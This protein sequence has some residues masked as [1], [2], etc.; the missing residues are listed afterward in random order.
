MKNTR[1]RVLFAGII[2]LGFTHTATAQ[3]GFKIYISA[4]M[5]G[6][7]GVVTGDQLGP[8]GFEYQRFRG[9]MTQEVNTAI[10][11]AFEGG[12]T[13]VV[14]S[15]S[16][17]NGENLLLEQ[18]PDNVVVIRSWPRPLSM[19]EGIDASFDGAIFLG[20]HTSTTNTR[21]VRAHTLS[22]ARLTAVRLNGQAMAEAGINAAIAG[23][24][25]VPII[26]VSGDDAIVEETTALLGD[27]EGAVVK[28]AL[29]FH[30]AKTLTP[31]AA[32]TVIR[33]KVKAAM[34]RI[35]DFKPYRL[36]GPIQLEVSFKNYRPVEMLAYL[37]IVERIDAHTIRFVGKDMI[38][39]SK[40]LAFIL[41]YT[42]DLSP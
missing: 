41:N 34:A 8:S 2:L 15:D 38:E 21:G 16:H 1:Y 18:L 28:W 11:A 24:F 42:P 7:V 17:G 29:G 36:D 12:A 13:E 30:S 22:S 14:V 4:D 40:F 5:E 31:E 19:M 33:Q 6:V 32:Y 20:Y 23:H 39:V 3:E 26:L 9:F 37:P 25:G 35:Q 10:E 27:V